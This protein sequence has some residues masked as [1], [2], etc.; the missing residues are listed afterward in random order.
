MTV[1][2]AEPVTLRLTTLD[3]QCIEA[4][5]AP[6]QTVLDAAADAGHLLPALC[7]KGT[8]GA[9]QATV[10]D[11]TYTLGTHSPQALS[12]ERARAA[13]ALLCCT[14]PEGPLAISLPYERSRILTGSIAERTATITALERAGENLV[15]L[16]LL[17]DEDEQL[18]SGAEFEPGQFAQL[19]VPGTDESRAHSYA[20]APNW[21]GE[22]EFYI[23][24]HPGGLFSTYLDTRAAPGDTLDVLG[25]QGAFG[26]VETGLRPR[27]FVAGGTGVAPLLSMARRMAEFQEPHP[28]RFYLGAATEEQLCAAAAVEELLPELPGMETVFCVKEPDPRPGRYRGRM[29]EALDRD[30]AALR[31]SGSPRPDLYICG[32]P[33]LIDAVERTAARHGLPPERVLSEKFSSSAT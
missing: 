13:G 19:V 30:L 28:L 27:W 1:P 20:N 11:G 24:L 26:L 16:V 33:G 8:C 29:I 32:S 31:A 17:L 6:G 14:Y 18:G 5:C 21:D 3:G 7:R 9:C 15:R 12:P 23:R 4:P 2:A 25:P 22:L 10:T